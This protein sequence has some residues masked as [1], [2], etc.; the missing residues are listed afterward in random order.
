[1][2]EGLIGTVVGLCCAFCR[3]PAT[4]EVIPKLVLAAVELQS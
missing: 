1:M 3:I 4:Y 2:G